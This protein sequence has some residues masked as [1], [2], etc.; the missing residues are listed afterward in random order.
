MM[1]QQMDSWPPMMLLLLLMLFLITITGISSSSSSASFRFSLEK[2]KKFPL[3]L[4]IEI[5]LFQKKNWKEKRLGGR[6]EVPELCELQFK[7]SFRF[8]FH[9]ISVFCC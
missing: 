9:G 6:R 2:K 3:E 1:I 7:K 5:E 8:S 4:K